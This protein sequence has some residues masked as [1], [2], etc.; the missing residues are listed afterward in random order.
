[1]SLKVAELTENSGKPCFMYVAER[2]LTCKTRAPSARAVLLTRRTRRRSDTV[3]AR[4]SSLAHSTRSLEDTAVITCSPQPTATRS[5]AMARGW[6]AHCP[7]LRA[8]NSQMLA[9]HKERYDRSS[10]RPLVE[11][12]ASRG[13][14]NISSAARVIGLSTRNLRRRP[15]RFR[16]SR[17]TMSRSASAFARSDA[18]SLGIALS[19]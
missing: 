2:M 4:P 11:T 19:S 17:P 1:M 8:D 10:E 9:A 12:A 18:R 6:T 14:K 13:W 16:S 5:G 3:F 15:G 7:F